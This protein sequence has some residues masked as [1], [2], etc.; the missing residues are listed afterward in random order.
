[1]LA[2]ACIV[3]GMQRHGSGGKGGDMHCRIGLFMAARMSRFHGGR[4]NRR[5]RLVGSGK[6][7][8]TGHDLDIGP[9]GNGQDGAENQNGTWRLHFHSLIYPT[10]DEGVK[11]SVVSV[12]EAGKLGE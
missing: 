8:A 3:I 1:M 9:G 7:P 12:T 5:N 4:F 11:I 6:G 2:T 10:V